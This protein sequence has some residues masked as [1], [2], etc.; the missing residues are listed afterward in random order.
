MEG[1]TITQTSVLYIEES[2]TII[3]EV[4]VGESCSI[5]NEVLVY[6]GTLEQFLKE[7]PEYSNSEESIE[8]L[9]EKEYFTDYEEII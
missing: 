5:S 8:P 9:D 4:F 1:I 7:N 6:V 3:G 2:K